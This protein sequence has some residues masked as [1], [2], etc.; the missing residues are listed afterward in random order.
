MELKS[1]EC[2]TPGVSIAVSDEELIEYITRELQDKDCQHYEE[3][4]YLNWY[5]VFGDADGYDIE[6]RMRELITH[7]EAEDIWQKAHKKTVKCA[8]CGRVIKSDDVT[9][10]CCECEDV[11]CY[12]C[13]NGFYICG[14]CEEGQLV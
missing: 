14:K 3:A 6:E 10:N 2:N 5:H 9:Y 8:E 1:V 11:M 4:G 7:E 12:E 13:G